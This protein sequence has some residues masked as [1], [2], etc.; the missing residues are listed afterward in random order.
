MSTPKLERV[1]DNKKQLHSILKRA[2]DIKTY[3]QRI[4]QIVQQKDDGTGQKFHYLEQ[5]SENANKILATEKHYLTE[6]LKK[7]DAIIAS[8]NS[9]IALSN[10][11]PDVDTVKSETAAFTETPFLRIVPAPYPALC[12]AMPLSSDQLIPKASFVCV[13]NGSDYILA[14]VLSFNPETFEY[15]VCDAAPEGEGVVELTI[16]ASKV[17]PVPT[18]APARRSKATTYQLNS[19][20]LALWPDEVGGWT[21]VFYPAT[22]MSQ[23]TSSPGVY[24]LQFDGD[25]PLMADVP[26]KF[27]VAA[28]PE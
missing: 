23:P 15:N 13:Q 3:R 25:P 28:P 18:T 1:G 21:S 4:N 10:N 24:N 14:I 12:G 19:R 7:I 8:R 11:L 22:V 6:M 26:E 16:P 27:I 17:M 9:M 20:V 2:H 5:L